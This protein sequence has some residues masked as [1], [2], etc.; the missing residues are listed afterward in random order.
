MIEREAVVAARLPALAE[1]QLAERQRE[2]V[3]DDQQVGQRR[4]LAGQHLA[5]GDA[6]IRSCRSAA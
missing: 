4:V 6:R 1:A 5:H 2:V 3:G